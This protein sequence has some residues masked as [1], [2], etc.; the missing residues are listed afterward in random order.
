MRT[1]RLYHAPA[2]QTPA[3]TLNS[4]LRLLARLHTLPVTLL[5]LLALALF[6]GCASTKVTNSERLV[7]GPLPR[8]NT[9]W[10]Y[11]F[12]A[13]AADLPSDSALAGEKDVDTT[14][15]T[16]EEVAAGRQLG[17]AIA[18]ELVAQIQAMGLPAAQ[19][20]ATTKP[21]VNDIVIRGYLLSVKAGSAAKRIVIGFGSGSS[22]LRTM[23][24]GFQMTATGLRKLGVGTVEA[25]GNKTPGSALGVATFLATANPAG[26]I[27]SAGSKAYGEAS[28][29]DKLEGRGKATAKEISDVLKKRFQ[30]QGWIQ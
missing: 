22:E 4:P 1:P 26:L 29:S 6:T 24:E 10:I 19:A 5:A 12:V 16:P 28:G 3:G 11:D 7:T 9:I 20:S 30:E 14:P 8:P 15:L 25:G 21:Q 2:H 18:T 23:V 27:I 17:A 13:N